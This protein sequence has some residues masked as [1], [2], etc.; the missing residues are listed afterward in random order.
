MN[1][2]YYNQ[3]QSV[4]AKHGVVATSEGLAAQAGMEILK[5]GG[6]A[7]DA[8]VATAAALT[9]VEPCSNG[10][11]SD[12]FALV[13]F[14]D[15][16]Y[17]MNS[18][19]YSSKNI[20]SDK[21]KALGHQEIPKY[22]V[23]PITVPGTPKG[24]AR[25]IERFGNLTLAEVLAPAIKLAREGFSISHSVGHYFTQAIQYYQKTNL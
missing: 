11:G 20:S 22:G 25:L 4:Y 8:A 19:G 3:R 2:P 6:N 9:V 23:I 1:N 17:G 5:A 7:V 14:K 10:I 13:Y 18:S 24:W 15:K 12:N 21:I 16:L